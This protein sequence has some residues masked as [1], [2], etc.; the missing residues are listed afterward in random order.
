MNIEDVSR[1]LQKKRSKAKPQLM[2]CSVRKR[3]FG[4][5]RASEAEF[6][7]AYLKAVSV[8]VDVKLVVGGPFAFER[9]ILI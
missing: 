8:A 1:K 4:R 9:N 7:V 2:H 5:Y 6:P 3:V